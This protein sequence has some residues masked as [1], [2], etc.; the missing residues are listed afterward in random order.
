MTYFVEGLTNGHG[1]E[2]NVRRIGECDTLEDAIRTSQQV[3][4]KSLI[5]WNYY[6][7]T[8]EELFSQ[9][10]RFGEVPFIFVDNEVT[11]NV[12]GFNSLLYAMK[13]CGVLCTRSEGAS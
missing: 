13:Q 6:G 5:A 7:M 11:M 3:I 10:Q 12:T 4:D 1:G 9:Y 8:V 2:G